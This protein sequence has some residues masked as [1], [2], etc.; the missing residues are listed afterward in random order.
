MVVALLCS[1][2]RSMLFDVV[3]MLELISLQWQSQLILLLLILV[4]YLLLTTIFRP[5]NNGFEDF[6]EIL[7]AAVN[8]LTG[9]IALGLSLNF[10]DSLI[11]NAGLF[12][13]NGTALLVFAVAILIS[14]LI[15]SIR[16]LINRCNRQK[17]EEQRQAARDRARTMVSSFSNDE[18]ND[19]KM[20]AVQARLEE[21]RQRRVLGHGADEDGHDHGYDGGN[22]Y[23]DHEIAFPSPPPQQQQHQQPQQQQQQRQ[24]QAIEMAVYAGK[25]DQSDAESD[26][27]GNQE[28]HH[29]HHQRYQ[30]PP[31]LV[32]QDMV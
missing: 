8:T 24:R 26:E 7:G 9:F 27:P 3:L 18:L 2:L 23:D 19:M 14:P 1:M 22:G 16:W 20:A 11:A 32:P 30:P 5:F 17:Q 29:P 28:P 10:V 6:L 4:S 31:R 21:A 15:F 25:N 13:F 12:L